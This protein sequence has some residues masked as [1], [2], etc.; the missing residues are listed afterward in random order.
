[1]HVNE[2]QNAEMRTQRS[3]DDRINKRGREMH[4]MNGRR[5][6]KMPRNDD[7]RKMRECKQRKT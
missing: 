5:S 3:R 4:E 7:L 6:R 2:M 1:M